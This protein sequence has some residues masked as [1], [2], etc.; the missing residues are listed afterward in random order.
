MNNFTFGNERYQYYET[1]A[2][3]A[4]AGPGLRRRERRADA[5]DQLAAH[6]SG[7]ARERA[8]RC[9]C[10]S[11]R[12]AHGSGG[13]GRA[14]RWRRARAPHRIPRVDDGGEC[15][16]NHRRIA[17]FGLEG[18]AAGCAGAQ[19]DQARRQ[20]V[21]RN[22]RRDVRARRAAGRPGRDRDAGRRRLRAAAAL[23]PMPGAGRAAARTIPAP[24]SVAA[25]CPPA[26]GRPVGVR[27]GSR[28]VRSRSGG[29]CPRPHR[30][31]RRAFG[32]VR[33][34]PRTERARARPGQRH[35][36]MHGA[37]REVH[38]VVDALVADDLRRLHLRAR[39]EGA[40]R[41]EAQQERAHLR[42]RVAA[43]CC[44][45]GLRSAPSACPARCC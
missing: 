11:S 21:V 6:R 27:T 44:G 38:R 33:D 23:R 8:F 45:R 41:R 2:G 31:H 39:A 13:A 15:S 28:T 20:P 22:A 4:G 25:R 24:A 17:P 16:P 32:P 19:F 36:A 10:A 35:Q 7:G 37:A 34:H 42:V 40:A 3:G 18:G 26:P 12:S 29:N 30:P 14:S 1:I 5:H 43:T 9:C